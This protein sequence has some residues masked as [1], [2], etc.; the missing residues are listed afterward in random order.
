MATRSVDVD[1]TV[2]GRRFSM[3]CP[4]DMADRM[5]EAAETLEADLKASLGADE[6]SN[7]EMIDNLVA[8]ALEYLCRDLDS[9]DKQEQA[10]FAKQIEAATAKLQKTTDALPSA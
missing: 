8:L 6:A 4:R 3:S 10:E 2:L 9:E 7:L 1:L 5:T